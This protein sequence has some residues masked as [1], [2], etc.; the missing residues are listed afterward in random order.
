MTDPDR[1][2]FE[3][4]AYDAWPAAALALLDGEALASKAGWTAALVV[5]DRGVDPPQPRTTLLS[6]GELYAPDAH[7]LRFSLW[8]DSRTARALIAYRAATLAF[9]AG[10]AFHQAQLRID[11]IDSTVDGL[12]RFAATLAGGEAQRVGYARVVSGI[13][14]ELAADA[15]DVLARWARQIEQLKRGG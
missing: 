5:V 15:P 8:P 13:T 6:A 2:A 7:T 3:R 11:S 1:R 12:A 9:V 4:A 10:H 14:F